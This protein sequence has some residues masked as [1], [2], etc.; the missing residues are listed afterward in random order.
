[1][2]KPNINQMKKNATLIIKVTKE[3]HKK[4]KKSAIDRNMS[5]SAMVIQ[6][7]ALYLK[8]FQK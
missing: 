5:M 2:D 6:A 4:I 1:M 3:E 7:I 8:K